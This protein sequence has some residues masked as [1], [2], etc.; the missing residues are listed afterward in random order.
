MVFASRHPDT[1]ILMNDNMLKTYGEGMYEAETSPMKP[2]LFTW[3]DMRVTTNM[4]QE[5]ENLI[6]ATVS[7][8]TYPLWVTWAMTRATFAAADEPVNIIEA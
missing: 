8:I 1:L 2:H 3:E 5:L 4:Q 6:V 7:Q